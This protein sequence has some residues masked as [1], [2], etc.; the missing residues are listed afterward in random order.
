MKISVDR[1]RLR[2]DGMLLTFDGERTKG[3]ARVHKHNSYERTNFGQLGLVTG[4]LR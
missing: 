4:I 1:P 3:V 2:K